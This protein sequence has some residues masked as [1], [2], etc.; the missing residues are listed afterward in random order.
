MTAPSLSREF[1]A[2]SSVLLE[3]I[4]QDSIH[5]ARW[6]VRLGASVRI[7]DT[8]VPREFSN[9]CGQL[10]ACGVIIQIVT[11]LESAVTR[12]DVV[13]VD[14]YPSPLRPFVRRARAQGA[15]VSIL[16]DLLLQLSPV[17]A[18]G[19]TGTAGKSSTTAM[20]GQI[21]RNSS[22]T[23]Y[24]GKDVAENPWLNCQVLEELDNMR[25]PAWLVAE[26][27]SSHLEY[28]HASPQVAVITNLAADHLEWHGS[29]E[30]YIRAKETILRHQREGDWAILNYD[31]EMVR[32]AFAP[33]CRARM[34]YFSLRQEVS[35]GIFVKDEQI[36]A[37]WDD[38]VQEIAPLEHVRIGRRYLGNLL[39]ACGAA[40]AAGGTLEG[41][42]RVVREFRGLAQRLE[43]VAEIRSI[44]IFNDGMAI[45]PKK[46]TA[47]LGSFPDAS[48]LWIAGGRTTASWSDGLHRSDEE[49]KLLEDAVRLGSRKAKHI[50]LFGESAPILERYLTSER[51]Q[52]LHRC[53]SLRSALATALE[54]SCTGDIVL[55]APLFYVT[56]AEGAA[57]SSMAREQ[58]GSSAESEA[59]RDLKRL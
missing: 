17:P 4:G 30:N 28:M 56:P 39:A 10:R 25:P 21:L 54:V 37:H 55:F 53:D 3:K 43:L 38:A 16:S 22:L 44:R 20:I 8:E 36:L 47:S 48:I 50:I 23:T 46:A 14:L 41:A 52:R 19:V 49:R 13:F 12:D 24:M 6:L 59:I 9:D 27:T 15:L 45:T 26:L 31:D 32:A 57:F 7:V 35:P 40:L 29:L 1:L 18:I 5:L 2:R 42:G 34:A 11:K 33:S 58:A 51:Y